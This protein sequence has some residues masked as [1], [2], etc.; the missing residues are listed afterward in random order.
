MR[1]EATS[2]PNFSV[3]SNANLQFLEKNK[4]NQYT[5]IKIGH[6]H[7]ITDLRES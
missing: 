3:G 2:K 6:A 1:H 4:G 5:N 7:T